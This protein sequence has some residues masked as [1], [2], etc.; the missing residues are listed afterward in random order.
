MKVQELGFQTKQISRATDQNK[1]KFGVSKFF[2]IFA[3]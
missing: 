3:L 1:A 2:P